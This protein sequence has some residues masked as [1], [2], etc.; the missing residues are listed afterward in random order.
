MPYSIYKRQLNI[1][2][3]KNTFTQAKENKGH[4]LTLQS[5]EHQ[6]MKEHLKL[7]ALGEC[8]PP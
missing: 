4:K 2:P 6:F 3:L 7:V 1:S 5:T 8:R